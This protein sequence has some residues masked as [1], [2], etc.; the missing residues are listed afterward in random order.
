LITRR[1]GP[2]IAQLLVVALLLGS[3]PMAA[4]PVLAQHDQ[5]PAF[6]LDICHPLPVFAIGAA[7]CTLAAFTAFSFVILIEDRGP[8]DV[9]NIAM[10]DRTG[11]APDPPPPKTLV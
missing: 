1:H 11:K 5:V 7:S 6:T 9:S 10:I 8:T 2:L 4:G 3:L